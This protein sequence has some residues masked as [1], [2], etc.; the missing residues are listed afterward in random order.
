MTRDQATFLIQQY[1]Q[2]LQGEFP[3]TCKVL[4]AVRED[5]CGYRPDPKSRT[6]WQLAVHLATSEI[7]FLESVRA[8]AFVMDPGGA[9][10]AEAA[11]DSVARLAAFYEGASRE[12][13]RRAGHV[14]RGPRQA[15]GLLRYVHVAS[16]ELRR[17]GEQSQRASPRTARDVPA[18][19]G[20]E[21]ARDLWGQRGRAAGAA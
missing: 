4:R 12:A 8:G 16:G 1:A 17:V 14:A 18:R 2:L 19:D 11:F 15:A 5:G 6:A 13:Q 7:W 10:K 3:A 9:A 21:G 20:I